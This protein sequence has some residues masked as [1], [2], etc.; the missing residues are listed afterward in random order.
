M[1]EQQPCFLVSCVFGV[2]SQG[3]L[4][5]LFQFVKLGLRAAGYFFTLPFAYCWWQLSIYQMVVLQLFLQDWG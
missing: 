4:P 1:E 2:C 5:V 3:L